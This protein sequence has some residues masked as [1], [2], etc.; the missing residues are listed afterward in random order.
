MDVY[1]SPCDRSTLPFQDVAENMTEH[2]LQNQDGT[3]P[4]TCA[5][6]IVWS[7][8]SL[9][10]FRAGLFDSVGRVACR[11][12]ASCQSYEITNMLW[13]F[14]ELCK[15]QPAMVDSLEASI[16]LVCDATAEVF[17]NRPRSAWKFPVLVSALVSLSTLSFLADSVSSQ[18]VLTMVARELAVQEA[19]AKPQ[20]RLPLIQAFDNL[21]IGHPEASSGQGTC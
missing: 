17:Q 20:Q 14:A 11:N 13:A 21:R 4:V 10:A 7:C 6:I 5:S 9:R 12:L 15:R 8:A 1:G 19:E 18:W 16:K 2:E 3:M